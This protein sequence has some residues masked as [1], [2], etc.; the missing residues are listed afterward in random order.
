MH[1]SFASARRLCCLALLSLVAACGSGS[2]TTPS[3]DP[4][5]EP[6]DQGHVCQVADW[7]MAGDACK[8]GQKIVFLPPSFGN[9]QLP[10]MFAAANCDL[11][12]A[13]VATTG[14]VTCIYLPMRLQKAPNPASAP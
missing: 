14:A 8:P 9:E 6:L 3:A 5:A 12:Y 1:C 10:V 2:G 13:V 7:R 11:R 4:I